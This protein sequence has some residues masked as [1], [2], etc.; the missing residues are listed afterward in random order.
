MRWPPQS[1]HGGSRGRQGPRAGDA[2]GVVPNKGGG[3]GGDGSVVQHRGAAHPHLGHQLGEPVLALHLPRPKVR[4]VQAWWVGCG[5]AGGS[6]SL[7]N[8][9]LRSVCGGAG[10]G[11]AQPGSLGGSWAG[12]RVPPTSGACGGFR[13]IHG[14]HEDTGCGRR[15]R[16]TTPHLTYPS[17]THQT[18][19]GSTCLHDGLAGIHGHQEDAEGGGGARGSQ[20]LHSHRQVVRGVGSL[21][22]GQHAGVGGS[23]AEAAEGPAQGGWVGVGVGWGTEDVWIVDGWMGGW[24]GTQGSEASRALGAQTAMSGQASDAQPRAGACRCCMAAADPAQGCCHS[25]RTHPGQ[26]LPPSISSSAL[27]PP[28]DQRGP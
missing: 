6:T 11:Q 18:K 22:Q 26:A 25:R 28:L 1:T 17:Q 27:P 16:T 9:S 13:D 24:V 3:G 7:P 4:G 10:E 12:R 8:P 5:G 23:V 15:R 14:H 19:E 2:P 20:R 21:Q